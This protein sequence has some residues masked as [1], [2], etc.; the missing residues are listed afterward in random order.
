MVKYYVNKKA[1]D[2]GEHAVHKSICSYLPI[3]TNRKFLGEF[4]NCED[5]VK[6]AQLHYPKSNGCYYCIPECYKKEY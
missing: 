5:A 3:K 6:R 1:Q 4:T 2:S